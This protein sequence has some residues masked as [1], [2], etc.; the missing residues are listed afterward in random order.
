M[1]FI[2]AE[3]FMRQLKRL[4]QKEQGIVSR[5]V[6]DLEMDPTDRTL[7]L[8]KVDGKAGWWSAYA[9]GDLRI[10]LKREGDGGMIL[11]WTDHHDK[12]YLW[13]S[14]HVLTEHPVT[15][16]MQLVEIPEVVAEAQVAPQPAESKSS[17]TNPKRSLCESLGIGRD[18]LLVL[19]VPEV[20]IE[21]VLAATEEDELLDIGEKHLPP[22]A[23]EAVLAIAVGDRPEMPKP[24]DRNVVGEAWDPQ[25]WWVVSK[26]DDL[27]TAIESADWDAWCVYLHPTQRKIAY[28]A[29]NGPFRV[30]GSAGTGKTVVALH[31]AKFVLESDC[32]ARVLVTTFSNPLADDLRRRCRPLLSPKALERCDVTTLEL[33]ARKRFD[34]LFPGHE[35][36]VPHDLLHIEALRILER[37]AAELPNGITPQFALSELERVVE[38]RQITTEDEY[39]RTR[40]RGVHRRLAAD[41]RKAIWKVLQHVYDGINR[42]DGHITTEQMYARLAGYYRA[43]PDEPRYHTH[44][45]V[46]ECQDLC[47]V[48]LD[49]LTA[50]LG[51]HGKSFFAGDI[52]QR[53]VRYSFP[54][55]PHGIDLRGRS[56]VLKVNYRTTQEI[57]SMADRLTNLDAADAD[58]VSQNRKGTIS[59]LS[60]PKPEIR[61]FKTR[62]EE[63]DGVAKWLNMVASELDIPA[64]QVAV[65]YRSEKEAAR[66]E[67]AMRRSV[68]GYEGEQKPRLAEMFEAKGLEYRAAVVMACDS[69]VIPSPGRLAEA[70]LIAGLEEI[71]DTE[72]NLL[73][74]ACT[75]ARDY[76]LITSA[77][78]PSEL[79]LDIR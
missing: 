6:L 15:H 10:I 19:G 8:H 72:R 42:I 37:H 31:H 48:E 18:E 64:S 75:R 30:C 63:I 71:Y 79:L 66:A 39:L 26:D 78:V 2:I 23:A 36:I 57:R 53:I 65:F 60:G 28:R 73:Y 61:Q 45:V 44:V 58:D 12:A 68:Y 54:W 59:L 46:D 4:P 25:S 20:W 9:N 43:H 67:E 16:T 47:E 52:G 24:D 34:A 21:R 35:P 29:H 69:D 76:L 62:E 14:R 51:E 1:A 7:S 38:P 27:K 56:R 40:R 32:D 11:C 74:V 5:T 33:F 17:E 77:G 50:Y 70:D 49:F 55:K 22:D 41:K 3:T 13:A